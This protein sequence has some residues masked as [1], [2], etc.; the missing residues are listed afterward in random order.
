[1]SALAVSAEASNLESEATN[2]I[3]DALGASVLFNCILRSSS[4]VPFDFKDG[5]HSGIPCV[6]DKK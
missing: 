3:V 5:I 2:K 6:K 1:M 4:N